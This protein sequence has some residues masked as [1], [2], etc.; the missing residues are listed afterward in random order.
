MLKRRTMTLALAGAAILPVAA[1]AQGDWRAKYP[2]LV[3]AVVPAENASG[4]TERF[5]P[6]IDYLSRTLGTK[7]TLRVATDYAAVIEGQRAGNIHLGYYGP[8][9]YVR[10][11]TVTKGGVEPFVTTINS[12][13]SIGYYS[14]AYV[15]ADDK[16]QKIEDL[17]GR[18][19]GLV[20][21]NSTSGNNVPRFSMNKMGIDP[22]AFFAKVVY[23]GSHE[24]A[25]LAVK[26]G[27]VDVA[28]NWWNSEKDSNLSRMVNK[29]MVK[30]EDVRMI[31]KSPLIAGSPYAWLASLPADAKA[32][33]LKA[34][35]DSP[36]ADKAAF[37]K[38]SD[39]K[40]LGFQPVTHK[41]YE[42]VVEL[43][44]FVDQLR[45]KRS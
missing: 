42:S 11:W 2:E 37:E 45:K 38:L 10:A 21:P 29:G 18:N 40:D 41:D 13:G 44:A 12:D 24:N 6:F 33:I 31:F 14:V 7:V 32:A 36:K 17:K 27:T 35:V 20:D 23:T 3:M 15:R 25:V 1:R 30:F 9:S 5:A 28:F 34:F 8:S 4:V 39:G 26:G 22:A 19:L 16:A 43:Q